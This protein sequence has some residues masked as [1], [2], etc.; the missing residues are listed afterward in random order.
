MST[1]FPLWHQHQEK[2]KLETKQSLNQILT[3]TLNS[4]IKTTYIVGWRPGK[5]KINKCC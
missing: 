3:K 1:I 5:I 2:S 4:V